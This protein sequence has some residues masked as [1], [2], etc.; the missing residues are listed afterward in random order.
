MYFYFKNLCFEPIHIF[1]NDYAKFAQRTLLLSS[2]VELNP[3]SSDMDTVL[4]SAIEA[5]EK[6][7]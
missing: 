6:K 7:S 4:T 2:D 1:S 5:S 3:R